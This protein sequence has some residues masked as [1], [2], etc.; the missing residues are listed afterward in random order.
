MV[1]IDQP[2]KTALHK[3]DTMGRIAKWT[4]ELTKFGIMFQLHP[5]IKAQVLVDFVMECTIL[6]EEPMEADSPV[7]G[8]P[9]TSGYCMCWLWSRINSCQSRRRHLPVT[10]CF[11]FLSTNNEIEYEALIAGLKISKELGVQHLKAC[12]DS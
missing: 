12:S 8:S 2:L 3:P 1:L 6:E 7:E 5:S 9:K 4:L 11:G 10:L